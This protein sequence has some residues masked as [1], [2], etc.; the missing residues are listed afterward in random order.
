MVPFIKIAFRPRL[1]SELSAT[2]RYVKCETSPFT[3]WNQPFEFIS[4]R[5]SGVI[6]GAISKANSARCCD[7]PGG[8]VEEK[9]DA[10]LFVPNQKPFDSHSMTFSTCLSRAIERTSFSSS[11]EIFPRFTQN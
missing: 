2:P 1:G 9:I 7:V 4:T 10:F 6:G 5:F 8:A 3:V 11:G